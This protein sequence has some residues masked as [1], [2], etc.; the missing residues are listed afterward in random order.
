MA[1]NYISEIVLNN[2]RNYQRGKFS[3]CRGFNILYGPNGRGKT[4]LLEAISLFSNSR[5]IRGAQ[6]DEMMSLGA[7]NNDLPDGAMFSLFLKLS[8]Y[9]RILIVQKSEKK[10]V[11]FNDELQRNSEMLSD[12]LKITYLVPQM[13][14]F[15]ID[16][17][18]N[19]RKF[20]DKT[21]D[22]LFTG[23]YGNVKKYEFFLRE[24]IKILLTQSNYS[25][26]LDIVEKKIAELGT[27]IA[28]VRNKTIEYLNRI[29]EEHT[30]E[31]PTGKITIDGFV[32]NMLRETKSIDTEDFYRKTL[33]LNRGVDSKAKRTSFGL[34]R[35]DIVVFNRDKNTRAEL[36]STG[37]QK[38]L[39]LSLI[40]TRAIFSKQI[41]RGIVILLLDEI[42]SHIDDETRRKFFLE[43]EKLNVQTFLSGTAIDNFSHLLES[44][45]EKNLI[46]L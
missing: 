21:G 41:G 7:R 1:E 24:R 40:V 27:A 8:D 23:H 36:C 28:D 15:F 19:R 10:L 17:P 33:F 43:L 6:A 13:D 29:F 3:F 9:S 18:D 44:S 39:L 5:G 42:C 32:E 35:S 11:T 25:K 20:I 4:N 34:H 37:E 26:W 31:F 12:T 22:M 46:E 30:S 16:S 2:F 45:V 14:Y 38:M